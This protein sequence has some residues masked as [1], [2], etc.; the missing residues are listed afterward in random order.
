[1]R[2]LRVPGEIKWDARGDKQKYKRRWN[3][4]IAGADSTWTRTGGTKT[5][6]RARKHHLRPPLP[7]TVLDFQYLKVAKSFTSLEWCTYQLPFWHNRFEGWQSFSLYNFLSFLQLLRAQ[8]P[9]LS[10]LRDAFTNCLSSFLRNK[11][12]G[13]QSFRSIIQLLA[14]PSTFTCTSIKKIPIDRSHR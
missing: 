7:R 5:D 3:D 1:M 8:W 13:R 4:Q 2:L 11:F 10:V 6:D 12:W 9:K 14:F